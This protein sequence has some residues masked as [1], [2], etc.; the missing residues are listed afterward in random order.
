MHSRHMMWINERVLLQLH[1]TTI[2]SIAL[3]LSKYYCWPA[4]PKVNVLMFTLGM[5][6]NTQWLFSNHHQSHPV[7]PIANSHCLSQ[8]PS[9]SHTPWKM[10]T[11]LHTNANI[12]T[13]NHQASRGWQWCASWSRQWQHSSLS[14]ESH[15][16]MPPPHFFTW[17]AGAMSS[18]AMWHLFNDKW[19]QTTMNK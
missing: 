11:P 10:A 16:P 5:I 7:P 14:G 12:A 18:W 9:T 15:N 19:Q 17:E 4:T 3:N 1:H 6:N 13:P 8:P 2:K